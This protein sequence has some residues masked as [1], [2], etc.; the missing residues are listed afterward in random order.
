[1]NM[2]VAS[3]PSNNLPQFPTSYHNITNN[4]ETFLTIIF[5]EY[6]NSAKSTFSAVKL[7][8][9]IVGIL[10]LYLKFLY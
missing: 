8:L 5:L 9:L 7:S 3:L 4:C 2:T 6:K 10:F 1:M